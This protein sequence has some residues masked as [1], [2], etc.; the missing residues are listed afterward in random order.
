MEIEVP[1]KRRKKNKPVVCP[2]G[3][4]VAKI[5]EAVT[6]GTEVKFL[7]KIRSEGKMWEMSQIVS[8]RGLTDV[9]V[10]LGFAGKTISLPD[11][12]GKTARVLVQ[13]RGGRRSG[14]IIDTEPA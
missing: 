12:G 8:G 11:L 6:F 9:L 14:K 5:A 4:H 7:W 3:W 13:T 1:E 2:P 10:D